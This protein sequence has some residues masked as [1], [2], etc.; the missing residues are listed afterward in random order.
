[1][2]R[3]LSKSWQGREEHERQEPWVRPSVVSMGLSPGDFAVTGDIDAALRH[4]RLRLQKTTA[5]E[6]KNPGKETSNKSRTESSGDQSGSED[7]SRALK[8]PH[9]SRLSS[10]P[11][12]LDS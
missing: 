6:A 2:R 9:A 3:L 11:G 5:Q 8:Q 12:F 4:T 7:P 10:A 1:M